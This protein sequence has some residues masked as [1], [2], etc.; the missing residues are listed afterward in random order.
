MGQEELDL[1][2]VQNW[3]RLGIEWTIRGY[4]FVVTYRE[5]KHLGDDQ[6]GQCS[7]PI[8]QR[9]TS[10]TMRWRYNRAITVKRA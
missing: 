8:V 5:S 2:N 10:M 6:F 7:G 9:F 1:M 4:S 3:S